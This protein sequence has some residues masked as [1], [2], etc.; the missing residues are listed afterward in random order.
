MSELSL[1]ESEWAIVECSEGELVGG[2]AGVSES[3][4]VGVC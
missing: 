4:L 2:C 3:V 1:R